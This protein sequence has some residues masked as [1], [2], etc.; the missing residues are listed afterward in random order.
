MRTKGFYMERLRSDS[1]ENRTGRAEPTTPRRQR[2]GGDRGR[3]LAVP[4][5]QWASGPRPGS[6]AGDYHGPQLKHTQAVGVSA[7]ATDRGRAQRLH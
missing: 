2:G 5:E 4:Q 7:S 6:R 3:P 1:R